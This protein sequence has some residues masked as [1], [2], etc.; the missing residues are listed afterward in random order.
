MQTK[1]LRFQ[2]TS[3]ILLLSVGIMLVGGGIAIW[4]ARTA[5]NNEVESSINLAL[6]LVRLVLASAP[7]E[8]IDETDWIFRLKGLKQTRHLD[9]QLKM[10]SGRVIEITGD[11][12]KAKQ[13]D[14]PP[15]WFVSLVSSEYPK[16]E[17]PI[18]TAEAKVLTLIIQANPLDEITEVW[19]ESVAFFLTISLLVLFTFLAVQ[20]VFNKSFQAIN[21]I[22][23][24]LKLIETGE[25]RKKLPEFSTLEYDNIARAIN[26]M[27]EVLA[28]TEQQNQAL[29]QHSLQIQEEERQRLS[30]ELHDE[31]GQSLTAIK[32]MTAT[33]T[34][35]QANVPQIMHSITEICDHLMSVVRS[36]MQQLHPLILTELGLKATLEDL[37]DHWKDRNPAL[38]VTFECDPEIDYLND[39]M[40]I[41]L[42]RVIQECLT[43]INRHAGARQVVIIM[44][45]HKEK[46]GY[47][48]VTIADDGEGCDINQ[49]S[50]G[51]GLLSMKERI[52]SLKGE[53]SI[54]SAP[55]EGMLITINI[56]MAAVFK[57]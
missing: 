39:T 44:N 2:I 28:R 25:Y 54:E 40:T 35:K 36:M 16:A 46:P 53:F 31:L 55:G 19:E 51:F 30:Q 7:N 23:D 14:V 33:A 6:Q 18:K 21:T 57:K 47:L 15:S 32:V 17:Y 22:V 4:Q 11:K 45:K 34:H 12:K 37:I 8:N 1:S 38:S 27:T 9:I 20:V 10:P 52:K 5:V 50:S 24:A 42:F 49:I 43:N 48:S 41:Q 13:Q 29:T 3:R 26:H 56:P